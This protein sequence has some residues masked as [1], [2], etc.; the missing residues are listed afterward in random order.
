MIKNLTLLLFGIF[1]S[2]SQGI[3]QGGVSCSDS[4]ETALCDLDDINGTVFTNPPPGGAVPN[5]ALCDGSGGFHNPGWFSFVAGSTNI[6]LTVTPIPG[7]CDTVPNGNFGVQVA[8]W[9]GCP[10]FGGECVAGDASCSDQPITLDAMDLVIGDIY[11]LVIDGCSGSVCTVEVTIDNAEAFQLPD[12]S[13]VDLF[14]PDYFF[15][16]GGSCDNALGDGNFCANLEV[17][18]QIDDD[19]YETLAAEY[20][21]SVSGPDPTTVEWEFGSFSGTGNPIEIGDLNGE[22]GANGLIMTFVEPG[23]YIVCIDNV[24]SEC[25]SDADGPLCETINIITPGDQLFD[26]FDVC[27][28]DLLAG[29]EPDAED[30]NGNPWIAGPITLDMVENAV[31]GIVEVVTLDDCGCSFTQI[32]EVTVRGTIDREEVELFIWECML[33]YEWYEE[34]FIDLES[35]PEG[36]GFLLEEGSAEQDFEGNTCDSLVLLTITPLTALDTIIVGNCTSEGTE[37]TFVF[38]ALDPDGNE[39]EVEIPSFQWIDSTS[40]MV[41]ANTQT[42]LLESGTYF[43][44]FLSFIEDLNYMDDELA[45]IEQLHECAFQ[46]GPYN[47]VGGSSTTPD[48]N[49]YDQVY[50]EDELDLLTFTID[51][52]PET[53]YN[54]IIPPSYNVLFSS[55]DSLAVSI[56][57]YVPTDTLFVT[58]ANSCGASVPFALPISVVPG[59]DV[60]FTGEPTLCD[61]EEYLTGYDGDPSLIQSYSWNVPD[62]MITTGDINSQNIGI[63]FTGPGNYSFSLTVTDLDGCSASDDFEVEII[64]VLP[65]PVVMCDGDPSQILFTWEAVPGAMD[66]DVQIINL[67]AGAN[68]ELIGTT[69]VVT[70]I[71]GGDEATII[72]T[73]IGSDCVEPGTEVTCTAPGCDFSGII[74]N[75]F[76]DFSICFGEETNMPMQFDITLPPGYTGTFSG[77]GLNASGLFD[78]TSTELVFGANPLNFDYIDASGCN[79]TIQAIATVSQLPNA[80]FTPTMSALC[81]GE[82]IVLTGAASEG[83]FDYGD[84][85]LGDFSGLSYSTSGVKTI[86]VTVTDP[87]SGCSDDFAINV[88]VSDTLPAPLISCIPGTS[89]IDFDWDDHPLAGIY[90][91]SVTINGGAPTV[92][93]QSNSNFTQPGLVEGDVVELTVTVDANNGCN[94]AVSVESCTAKTCIIPDINLSAVQQTFCNNDL[95]TPVVITPLVDGF[96]PADNTFVFVGNGLTTD[97]GQT[98]FDPSLVAVGMTR[99]TFRYTNPVDGCVTAEVIDFEI[100]DVPEPE[101]SIDQD[102]ICIDDVV[103]LEFEAQPANVVARPINEAGGNL[104]QTG[105]DMFEIGWDV[106]GTFDISLSYSV[107]GCPDETVMVPITVQ[108]TIQ[109]PNVTC[110]DVDTDF[111]QFGWQDQTSVTEYEVYIDNVLVSTQTNSDFLLENLD[112][113]QMVVIRVVAKD[114]DCGD[115]EGSVNCNS[116]DCVPPTWDI[117]VPA[118]LCFEMGSGSISLDVNAVSNAMGTG[119]ITWLNTEVD[120]DGNFTPLDVSQD[121]TITAVYTEK[122]CVTDTSFDIRVNVIPSAG[123]EL[124]SP[125][126]I[127]VGGTV[128][129]SSNYTGTGSEIPNWNFDSGMEVGSDFGPYDVT[130]DTPGTYDISLS[131]DNNGCIGSVESVQITVEE[132]LLAPEVVCS[133]SDI[134]EVTVSWNS[135]DCAGD[136]RVIVDG[137]EET[138][139]SDTEYTITGLV[140]NQ[141]VDIIVE[142]ISE[143]ACSNVLSQTFTCQ[144]KE[145][146]EPTWD[147]NVPSSFCYEIGSGPILLDVIA[148][149]N[150]PMGSGTLSW[151]SPEVDDNGNFTPSNNSQD[152]TLTLLYTEGECTFTNSVDVR[153]NIIPD[154]QLN[155]TGSNIICEGESVT[156]QSAFQSSSN[157]IP[158]WDFGGGMEV[159]S[160]FGPYDVTFDTPGTYNIS[161]SIDNNGCI[162]PVE[163]VQITV[164]EELLAPEVVCSSSDINEITVNWNSVDCAGDY[165]VIVDGNEETITSDTEYTITGLVENQMV[166]II[167]EAISECA[168]NN[169]LSQTFT[170]QSKE[171]IEPTWDIN[172]PSSFCYEIGSGPILLDV[173]ATSNEPVGSGTLSWT[174]PEVDDNGNFTP[175]NNSQDYT[176]TLLYTEGECTFTNSVD[177]R[178]NIIPDA[179][180]NLTGSNIICEGESVTVQSAFQSSSNEIP[181]WDFGGGIETGS[182]FGPYSVQ[183]NTPGTYAI[184]LFIDNAGCIGDTESV[185][186]EVQANL[187]APIIDCSTDNISSI[188]LSWNAVDCASD[189]QILVDGSIDGTTSNTNYMVTGLSE[190]QMVDIVVEAISECACN[191]VLSQTVSC[192][193]KPCDQTSWTFSNNSLTDI[194]LDA[195]AQSFMISATPDDLPGNGIGS[196][197]GAPISNSNGTVDPSLV[198]AGTYDLIYTYEEG[199]CTYQAPTLQVT[200]V[201]EPQLQLTAIDPSCPMD[202]T[203]TI[204][205]EGSG[206]ASGYT[207]AIDGG[208]FQSSGSFNDVGIGNHK[209][210]IVD[211]NGCV[212]SAQI[213]LFAPLTPTVKIS[214]PRTVIINNDA[215]FSVDIQN[216]NDIES[217][218]WTSSNGE[219]LCQGINCLTYTQINALEDFDLMVEVVYNGGCTVFSEV[220]NVDVKEI[221]AYYIPN[222]VSFSN[223]GSENSQWKIFIKGNETFPRSIKVYTRWGNLIYDEEYNITTPT[224]EVLLWNGESGDNLVPTGVYVY[225]LEIEIEERLEFIVGDITILR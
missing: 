192:S 97:M 43:V 35:L 115:K 41:I 83:I 210:D 85:A 61:G 164:E 196:W 120:A 90:N 178:V 166:D 209:V 162:G 34:E 109:S 143:C 172:V 126:V 179:Q 52:L 48:V 190:N 194:C 133:S 125:D 64:E 204:M 101:F 113:V 174:S 107:A 167:V 51:T 105:P 10:D 150:E 104:V 89:S 118:D 202:L 130:F 212:N 141:M 203:G 189:Y 214:G 188:Q 148:T 68:G 74:N 80:S 27:A 69:Y 25:D 87:N 20:Y 149:S 134:N 152:Y 139:T 72:V 30:E 13:T 65:S 218:I 177:V 114:S 6:V 15:S 136:Y 78:P 106:P 199:G 53:V 1:I 18:F 131:V 60:T 121:Y 55:E 163:S 185:Q 169:V 116:Q 81:V 168:C 26:Q 198:S 28:L 100:V 59:P 122:N 145:C 94:T 142:A 200:F 119:E 191:N 183:F 45:G 12:L 140:E 49:P 123:L 208:A 211:A 75:N 57:T 155:L 84:D 47:L 187:I 157:E 207:F 128:T 16:R 146:I 14:E 205:A 219:I 50:C 158:M 2:F 36:D 4:E 223:T 56:T 11:N 137:N 95:L 222:V 93:T 32:M 37:F 79:G 197:S 39:I 86:S 193:S 175:S 5:E 159:G 117:N 213:S 22:L 161:L 71:N 91:L 70:N 110:I 156:V 99:I 215:E 206:G 127:C 184:S 76:N 129:V 224:A 186:L 147:I 216:A 82:E 154:A 176:L 112:P 77:N 182:G 220:F 111:I 7:T 31:D 19:F 102:V 58:A 92:S 153:V 23:E 103:S 181:M 171:C 165:R 63:T 96:A 170:C 135:I 88:T 144:S 173:I 9:E 54:W 29:W 217:I 3:A 160:D 132:E 62:G 40:M 73:T 24:I 138:I 98:S 108:D 38:T 124:L 42:A 66:Y 44:N 180:L 8:L 201:E 221:Q 195:N 33:P 21:W 151:T 67:P 46:F 225:A 17:L